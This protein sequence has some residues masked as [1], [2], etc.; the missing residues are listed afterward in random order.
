MPRSDFAAGDFS[1]VKG[2]NLRS[3]A[4]RLEEQEYISS[5]FLFQFYV[6]LRGWEK[7]IKAGEYL[8]EPPLTVAHVARVIADGKLVDQNRNFLIAEGE[9]LLEIERNLKEEG[10]IPEDSSLSQWS[11]G[12][13]LEKKHWDVL[14]K[15]PADAS[16]EGFL[17]PDSYHLP[18]GLADQEIVSIFVDNFVAKIGNDL[19]FEIKEQGRSFYEILI[20]ASLLEKEVR[21]EEDKRMVADILWRRLDTDFPLQV[22]ATVCYAQ[23]QSFQDCVLKSSLFQKDSPYNT[24]LYKGL[25]PAPI[26]NPGLESIQAAMHPLANDFWYYLTDRDTG[27]TVFSETY[28][29]H[30]EAIEKHL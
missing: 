20:M 26:D 29:E 19:F 22:D 28:D 25:P 16:L 3:I 10:L 27:Q 8:F 1:V 4:E 6:K 30:L 13:F 5:S 15:I 11:A 2:E 7:N 9:T 24:Y 18:Q 14:A 23:F 12:D 17:F 21:G